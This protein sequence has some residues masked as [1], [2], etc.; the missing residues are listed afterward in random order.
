MKDVGFSQM[1]GEGTSRA[2]TKTIP[3]TPVLRHTCRG[4]WRQ[5]AGTVLPTDTNCLED[6]LRGC[7]A[8]K[9]KHGPGHTLS[10]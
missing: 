4:Q 6:Q 7:R 10:A 1:L 3:P 8:R 2:T 5:M 9:G